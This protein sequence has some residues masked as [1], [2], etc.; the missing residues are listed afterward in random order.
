MK[1]CE[2]VLWVWP[3][4]MGGLGRLGLIFCICGVW[5]AGMGVAV[6][7]ASMGVAGFVFRWVL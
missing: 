5:V 4:V 1:V 6:W 3:W 7:I 2:F